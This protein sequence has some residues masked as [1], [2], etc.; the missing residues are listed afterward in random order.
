MRLSSP[1]ALGI[2]GLI[3][4]DFIVSSIIPSK[5]VEE[6]SRFSW[7]TAPKQI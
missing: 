6:S 1:G 2:L 5:P 3:E 7:F 4:S